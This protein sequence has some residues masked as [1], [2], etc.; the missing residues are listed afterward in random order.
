M[1][2]IIHLTGL[3]IVEI[4]FFPIACSILHNFRIL[5][6][7]LFIFSPIPLRCEFRA[8]LGTNLRTI[9]LLNGILRAS[10]FLLSPFVFP[11]AQ[12]VVNTLMEWIAGALV[13][14]ERRDSIAL[15][16][17][18]FRVFFPCIYLLLLLP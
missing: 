6:F 14:V 12:V 13:L 2:T 17:I 18:W 11:F 10:F 15:V 16:H 8:I 3:F 1:L 7:F 4:Y 5:C 9:N